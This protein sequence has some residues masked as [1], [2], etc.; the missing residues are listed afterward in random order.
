VDVDGDLD[1]VTGNSFGNSFEF[2]LNDGQ[3]KFSNETVRILPPSIKG[4]GIDIEA[5]DYNGD[6]KTDLF[7]CNF[8]GS[9]MLLLGK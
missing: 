7:F 1:I 4:D 5:A 9:D 2:Y 8:Q 6:G 3:G